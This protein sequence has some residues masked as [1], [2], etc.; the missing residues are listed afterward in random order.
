MEGRSGRLQLEKKTLS[1]SNGPARLHQLLLA[2]AQSSYN[3][4]NS[5][6]EHERYASKANLSKGINDVQKAIDLLTKTREAVVA[7]EDS[8]FS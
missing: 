4:D 5:I 1:A 7:G 2:K 8:F 6:K 3:M